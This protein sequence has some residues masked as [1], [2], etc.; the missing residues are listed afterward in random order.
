[1]KVVYAS[2][3]A[4]ELDFPAEQCLNITEAAAR[5]DVVMVAVPGGA[6][7]KHLINAAVFDA[8]QSHAVFVNIARGDVVD[9]AALIAALQN[10]AIGGAGL[11]VY[12]FEPKV[13][14][15]LIALENVTLFPH[16]GTASLEVRTGM[17]SMALDN[18]NAFLQVRRRRIWYN[19]VSNGNAP[20]SPAKRHIGFIAPDLNLCSVTKRLSV[21]V[22]THNHSGL[23]SAVANGS[24]FPHLI[25][26]CE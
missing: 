25:G 26:K 14:S 9:E 16:L 7:T 6:D 2:R 11:D 3:S 13:P 4:K 24:D 1:M 23:F 21:F 15:E 8:M 22:L 17:G 12:E 20:M 10:G 19:Q 18:I 5:A